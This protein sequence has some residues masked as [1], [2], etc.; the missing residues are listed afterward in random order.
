MFDTSV[1]DYT[2]YRYL[3]SDPDIDVFYINGIDN[4]LEQNTGAVTALAQ[5][6]NY[7]KFDW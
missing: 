5:R 2:A 4:T 7:L 6:L 3:C 1:K